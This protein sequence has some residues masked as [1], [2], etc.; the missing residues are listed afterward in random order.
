MAETSVRAFSQ[1]RCAKKLKLPLLSEKIDGVRNYRIGHG[2][3][4]QDQEDLGGAKGLIH[5]AWHDRDAALETEIGAVAASGV[6]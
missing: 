6:S 5:A 2:Q 4:R 3:S 1:A